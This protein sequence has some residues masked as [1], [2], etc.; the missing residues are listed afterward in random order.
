MSINP[1]LSVKTVSQE[2]FEVDQVPSKLWNK[3][4]APHT[5]VYTSSKK[6]YLYVAMLYV[7]EEKHISAKI[8]K[9]LV[10]N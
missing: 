10:N 7:E 4:H 6:W 3:I 2:Y 8:H 5:R 1:L 9:F